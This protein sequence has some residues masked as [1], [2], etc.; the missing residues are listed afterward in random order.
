MDHDYFPFFGEHDLLRLCVPEAL[1][2]SHS[3]S[4]FWTNR[5]RFLGLLP[6]SSSIW[7]TQ[8]DRGAR[9]SYIQTVACLTL[10][11]RALMVGY[12]LSKMF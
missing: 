6:V 11:Y 10:A 4:A 9:L 3:A 12:H 2:E 8:L 1:D 7:L 5:H